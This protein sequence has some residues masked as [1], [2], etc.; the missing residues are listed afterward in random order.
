M[1]TDRT[2]LTSAERER[3]SVFHSWSAQSTISPL[4]VKDSHGVY[5]TDED[6]TTYLDFSSQLVNTNIGHQHPAVVRAIQ[7][8]AATRC[9]IAPHQGYVARYRAA[10]MILDHAH[11]G[12]PRSSS[13]TAVPK[14]WSTPC[15]W[16]DCTLDATRSC[17]PTAAATGRPRRR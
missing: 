7:E 11:E 2:A 17:R 8:Q 3:T 9:T 13:P 15:E 5:V 10:E 1:A 16:P 4:M 6:G 14:P 12:R